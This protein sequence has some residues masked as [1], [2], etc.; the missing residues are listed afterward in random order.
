MYN[1]FPCVDAIVVPWNFAEFYFLG[2]RVSFVLYL[3]E[4]GSD[5]APVN[6]EAKTSFLC[7]T[8]LGV[9]PITYN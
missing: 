3:R 8:R 4:A 9:A 7:P 2:H 1:N 6:A 5:H